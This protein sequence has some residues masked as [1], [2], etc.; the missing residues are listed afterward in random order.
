MY[1]TVCHAPT[2]A[3]PPPNTRT[4]RRVGGQ[5][6]R[7]WGCSVYSAAFARLCDKYEEATRVRGSR[8][9]RDPI[10]RVGRLVGRGTGQL[11]TK[12]MGYGVYIGGAGR[13]VFHR[14]SFAERY[15][16][17]FSFFFLR[18]LAQADSDCW[19]SG[20]CGTIFLKCLLFR[21]YSRRLVWLFLKLI[22]FRLLLRARDLKFEFI[23][24]IIIY[25]ECEN[26]CVSRAS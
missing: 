18:D 14:L 15:G 22:L 8:N 4:R 19:R 25:K 10:F 23:E 3:P 24:N 20:C 7:K 26:L 11:A 13:C 16:F 12:G 17:L 9:F 6:Y 21:F 5:G 1:T 2:C